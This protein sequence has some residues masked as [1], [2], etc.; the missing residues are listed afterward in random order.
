MV[1]RALVEQSGSLPL[2]SY[3]DSQARSEISLICVL[4]CSAD[5]LCL[6]YASAFR[7][8][9]WIAQQFA[10]VRARPQTITA[11][12]VLFWSL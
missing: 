2:A 4:G 11:I 9:R 8:T 3:H 12:V 1:D 6:P 10:G 7:F 5:G